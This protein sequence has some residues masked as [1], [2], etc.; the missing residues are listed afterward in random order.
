M[1]EVAAVEVVPAQAVV[2]GQGVQ[3]MQGLEKGNMMKMQRDME[4]NIFM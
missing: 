2:A 4:M 1:E 3:I